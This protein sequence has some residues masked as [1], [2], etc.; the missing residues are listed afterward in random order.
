MD[1]GILIVDDS[2]TV[3][4][5]LENAFQ[6]AGYE[7]TL[8]GTLFAAR[9]ALEKS[10][11]ALIVLDVLLPDGDGVE[12]LKE[13]KGKSAT[14]S[15]PVMLLSSEAE[16]QDRIRGHR[17]GADDYVGKPYDMMYVLGRAQELISQ[18]RS[19]DD[20]AHPPEVLVI[21]D[22]LTFREALKVALEVAG[23]RVFLA[24]TGEE[25]LR[26]AV[27]RRPSAVIVDGQLP[28]IDGA[29]V[30]RRMRLN[31]ALRRMPSLL[32]TASE[33]V[34]NEVS[35]LESG[36]DAYVRKEEDSRV[37]LARLGALLRASKSDAQSEIGAGSLGPKKVLAVDDSPTYL[38]Q[39]AEALRQE[40]YDAV[41]A[42]SG[43]E[44]LE[45]LAVHPVDCI[46]M[47]LIMPGLSGQD[48]CRHIKRSPAWRDIPLIIL[49]A[50]SES[51][52]MIAG[53]NA[54]ADDYLAKSSEF[55]ILKARLRAQLRRKQFED[56]NRRMRE[57]L[58]R[59][60]M[61][62]AEARAAKELAATRA[63]LLAELEEKNRELESFS[64]AVSHD[65]R[66]PLRAISGYSDLLLTDCAPDLN[67]TGKSY[68]QKITASTGRM[69]R[70]IDDLLVL[71]RVTR[72]EF[73]PVPVDL[74]SIVRG[75]VERLRLSAPQREVTFIIPDT[76]PAFGDPA[77]LA[78]ALE[79]LIGNAWKY[80]GK[81]ATAR[82]ELGREDFNGEAVYFV[83]DDGAGFDMRYVDSLFT[84]FN[85]LHSGHEFEGTGIGL[86]T[87]NRVIRR[88]SG[89]IWAEG[90]V[91]K[92]AVFKFVLNTVVPE[93]QS[94]PLNTGE[95]R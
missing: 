88:H 27:A 94:D 17:T 57:Q 14:G 32:L 10:T 68:L 31:S 63:K 39:L 53:I 42:R 44:A 28:G 75:I 85:R 41:L 21:D 50:M 47:D 5:D 65:L 2:L 46:L 74:S 19:P 72:R 55:E 71:S 13:L 82:I 34:D 95:H 35:I 26:I 59:K 9:Q 89:R 80:T 83:R 22:S 11:Y 36:A 54:G 58:L 62:A 79:N 64:Y 51:E 60:E 81:H 70:L 84:A 38:N 30:I 76:L 33:N 4:K 77:L 25:G 66:A 78:I 93:T 92:G 91:E 43:E 16:V 7:P 3:R 48:A 1:P 73:Q 69:G 37:V 29:T 86:A 18:N 12:F 56:E 8:C 15:V 6:A 87:V 61:E 67:E 52:S 24:G 20:G 23:Y 90:A 49:T 45:L 40:G